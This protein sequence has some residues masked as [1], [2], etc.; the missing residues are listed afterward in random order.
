VVG[1]SFPEPV[2]RVSHRHHQEVVLVSDVLGILSEGLFSVNLELG[3]GDGS[4]DEEEHC[5]FAFSVEFLGDPLI[6]IGDHW[7]LVEE[8]EFFESSEVEGSFEFGLQFVVVF[9][10]Y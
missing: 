3:V 8:D 9:E 10:D 7:V 5:A 4:I 6:E 1:K 2:V